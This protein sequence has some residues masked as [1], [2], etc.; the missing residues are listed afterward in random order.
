VSEIQINPSI[1]SSCL[2]TCN[3]VTGQHWEIHYYGDDAVVRRVLSWLENCGDGCDV[4]HLGRWLAALPDNWALIAISA[5]CQVAAV[6]KVRSFPLFYSTHGAQCVVSNSAR[7]LHEEKT[8]VDGSSP[9]ILEFSMA[10][11]TTGR[12]TLVSDVKQLLPG[13]IIFSQCNSEPQ[14]HRYYRYLPQPKS[15]FTRTQLVDELAE[16]TEGIFL[17]MIE[18]IGDRQLLVPLSGGLDSRLI[19]C[20]LRHLG[21]ENVLTYS[22]GPPGNYEAKIAQ[23]VATK[24]GYPWEFVATTHA[25]FRSYFWSSA[26]K[27]YWEFSD[28]LSTIPNM[29]DIYPL[30]QLRD[31]GLSKDAI[32][33]NGQSGD[34]ISGGHIPAQILEDEG[35]K[36]LL[37]ALLRKHFAL[38]ESLRTKENVAVVS[39][40]IESSLKD[41]EAAAGMTLSAASLYESWEW[42]ERQC[43]YVIGGQRIYD[44]LGMDWRLPLWDVAYLKFWCQVP[45]EF[46]LNQLLYKEYLRSRDY[47]G[48]FRE[49]SPTVWRWPGASMAVLPVAQLVGLLGGRGAK[50]RFYA[51]AR[52]LGHYGPN[53]APWGWRRFLSEATDIR[54]PVSLSVSTWLLEAGNEIGIL[55]PK[56]KL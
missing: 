48:L 29:Q 2:P 44:W 14:I 36:F 50:Q 4:G 34:F 31:R 51:Y 55:D 13:E 11:Y 3:S 33:V 22:Y 45:F 27:A 18:S 12:D 6:D 52:Y 25:G 5:T 21:Y 19:I 40:R 10:G 41:M 46:K 35:R 30:L 39:K 53:Y 37:D 17:R 56:P 43:K 38:R 9:Q 23:H 1:L 47:C 7:K 28:G 15:G 54:N 8:A 20:M 42:Q 32:V 49:F 26:R 16:T 24:A